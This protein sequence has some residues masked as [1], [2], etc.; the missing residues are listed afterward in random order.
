MGSNSANHPQSPPSN[1]PTTPRMPTTHHQRKNPQDK[2]HDDSHGEKC[3]LALHA[4]WTLSCVLVGE[5]R[6]VMFYHLRFRTPQGP[7]A[8]NVRVVD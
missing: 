3:G 1:A 2:S 7:Q 6:S 5:E 4:N 8:K